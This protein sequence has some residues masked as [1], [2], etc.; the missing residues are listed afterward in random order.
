MDVSDEQ[1]N[2]FKQAKLAASKI[3]S[4][5]KDGDEAVIIEMANPK[6]ALQYSFSRNFEYLR[7]RI[8]KIQISNSAASLD[9]AARISALLSEQAL[10]RLNRN[11]FIISD[12]QNNIFRLT[13][14]DSLHL[15]NLFTNIYMIPTG[16]KSKADIKNLRIDSLNII[17]GIFQTD[18]VVEVE[19]I[20]K[21]DSKTEI[22][23]RSSKYVF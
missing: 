6:M 2:R 7:D 10:Y 16:L 8:N 1:G 9:K 14:N 4:S 17:S 23:G 20:V 15:N 18:K 22:N 3:L 11:L 19:A 13:N 12:A 21:N 5:L